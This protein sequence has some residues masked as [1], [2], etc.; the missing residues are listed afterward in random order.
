MLI[1]KSSPFFLYNF[2]LLEKVYNDKVSTF[3]FLNISA[4]D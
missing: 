2:W 4:R 3:G 1:F